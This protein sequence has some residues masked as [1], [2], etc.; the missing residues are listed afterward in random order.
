MFYKYTYNLFNNNW[1]I[2]QNKLYILVF[3]VFLLNSCQI[4]EEYSP[5]DNAAE[6]VLNKY[7]E[8]A[9]NCINFNKY[10]S[11]RS[12]ESVSN[13]EFYVYAPY[14]EKFINVL[15]LTPIEI[16]EIVAQSS[17]KNERNPRMM[18]NHNNSLQFTYRWFRGS[19]F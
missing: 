10:K 18:T 12:D 15:H 2:Q 19:L 16:N 13:N 14:G 8:Q 1:I 17:Y 6:I 4:N 11:T 9:V 3:F 7:Y 5:T